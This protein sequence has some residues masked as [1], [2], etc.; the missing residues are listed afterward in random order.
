MISLRSSFVSVAVTQDDNK[1]IFNGLVKQKTNWFN[2][3]K[4]KL[5]NYYS[6]EKCWLYKKKV[7]KIIHQKYVIN[8]KIINNKKI[9]R[10]MS[11]DYQFQDRVAVFRRSFAVFIYV[12]LLLGLENIWRKLFLK[13]IKLKKY[14]IYKIFLTY[15]G[16]FKLLLSYP[17]YSGSKQGKYMA[18]CR[19]SRQ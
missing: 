7:I 14:R 17:R 19:S 16:C 9:Q 18:V 13:K 12:K 3:R 4:I 2:S 15:T 1:T 6:K 5:K 11:L 10:N 8:S